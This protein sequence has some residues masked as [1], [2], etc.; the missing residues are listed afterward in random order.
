L[1][2]TQ[3]VCQSLTS[4]DSSWHCI[5]RSDIVDEQHDKKGNESPLSTEL[6]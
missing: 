2:M 4:L 1:S 3:C 6:G 5:F